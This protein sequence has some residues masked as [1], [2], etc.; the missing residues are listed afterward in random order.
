MLSFQNF[1]NFYQI[2]DILVHMC[3]IT[4]VIDNHCIHFQLVPTGVCFSS[5]MKR[6]TSLKKMSL[7][8]KTESTRHIKFNDTQESDLSSLS[9][10]ISTTKY[11]FLTFL[12][13]YL[14]EQFRKYWNVYFLMIGLMQQI[15]DVSP[16][17][18]WVNFESGFFCNLHLI[19][20]V[21]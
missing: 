16:T 20:E 5:T 2:F 3:Y 14:Y 1:K 11:N 6:N 13:R 10:S 9:N 8:K 15:P 12:P 4:Y 18:R 7:R 19:L 21:I 17:G